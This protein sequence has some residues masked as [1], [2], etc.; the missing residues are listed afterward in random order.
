MKKIII[1]SI[2]ILNCLTIIAQRS[3][4]YELSLTRSK[5]EKTTKLYVA[6]EIAGIKFK[7]SLDLEKKQL[8]IKK[9]LTQPVAATIYTNSNK[10]EPLSLILANNN[11]SVALTDHSI[12]ISKSKLQDDFLYLTAN[13]RIRPGYFPL[14]GELS[15]KND[16][17]GLNK[18]SVIFDS[19]K[20][21]DVKKSF[22]YFKA[23]K[24]SLLSLYSFS[25][26]AAFFADYSKVEKDFFLLTTWA[27]SS[28]DGKSIAAK[29][30]GAK[31][32]QINTQAKKFVQQSSTGQ[33]IRL[34]AFEGKYVLL[35]FWASWCAPCRKEHPNLIKIYELFKNKNF[36]I[37]SISLDSENDHWLNAITK[38]KLTW[39]QISDLKG[40]QNDIAV[41]YGVQSV[42]ANFLINP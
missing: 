31:S 4:F 21:D 5:D 42:P 15:A 13:D 25:R 32:A 36:E 33:Q 17:A 34:E 18:L 39:T 20:N 40:Q 12:S 1:T 11:I 22:A 2:I 24:N 14:Y 27:K 35:D 10:I 19:L 7:D 9:I 26:F 3:F 30:A 16:T 28:P 8:T 23:N 38:D 29:I 41:Q 6:Y 37:I